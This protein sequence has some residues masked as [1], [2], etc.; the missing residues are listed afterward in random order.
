MSPA[1][2]LAA[3]RA[4]VAVLEAGGA[5]AQAVLPFG[6]ARLDGVFPAGGLPLGCWHEVAGDGL[7][8]ETA[9]AP[10]AFVANLARPLAARG[11]VV[12]VMRRGD[13]YAPGLAGLGFPVD[14]L[15]QVQARD[16]AQ[17]LGALEDALGSAGVTAAIGEVGSVDLTAGRRLQLACERRGATGF[18]I[19]RRPF[20]GP[21]RKPAANG[22]SGSA[23][24]TRWTVTAAPSG[25]EEGAQG[26]TALGV[27][28]PRWRVDLT[29]CRGGR[30]GQW[31]L[32][33]SD[34]A[35]P[36]RVVAALGD[37]QLEAAQPWR[38]AG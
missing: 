14:R 36:L 16:E 23:A 37:R 32:E 10:G 8:I 15:I 19:R 30:S 27:G 38:R 5:R 12:W 13:L 25:E 3:V 1:A 35:Y 2:R 29:R 24:A 11:T 34:G 20:G 31:I 26:Q 28:P 17:A 6:D 4:Q 7:E 21:P 18:V 22:V 33:M 9:A